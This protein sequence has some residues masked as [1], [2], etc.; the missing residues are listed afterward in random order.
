[1]DNK[2]VYYSQK[3]PRWKTTIYPSVNNKNATIGQAGCGPT[4]AAMV[5]ATLRDPNVTPVDTCA[6]ASR[7]NYHTEGTEHAYFKPQFEHYQ[8]PCENTWY[9]DKAMAALESGLMVIGLSHKGLWTSGGHYILAYGLK[10]GKILINDPNSVDKIKSEADLHHWNTETK[11]WWII[12]EEWNVDFNKLL[13]ELTD[14]QAY[15]LVKKAETY[16]STLKASAYAEESSKKAILSGIF[17]D[18]DKDKLL[19][20]PKGFVTREQLAVVFNRAGLLDR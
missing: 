7:Y 18:G 13:N 3:D 16:A 17:T 11:P 1:M 15:K 2:P 9:L 6:W 4:C 12:R 20:S 8:I 5:I 19:D 14:E 10:D